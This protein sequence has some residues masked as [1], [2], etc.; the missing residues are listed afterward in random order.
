MVEII[1]K[2]IEEIEA[3]L[4]KDF[5]DEYVKLVKK[6]KRTFTS[7]LAIARLTEEDLKK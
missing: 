1:K 7:Q 3:E 5:Y 2:S 4:D 6:Y